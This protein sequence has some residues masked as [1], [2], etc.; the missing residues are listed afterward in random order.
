MK[1]I[2]VLLVAGFAGLSF[3][4]APVVPTIQEQLDILRRGKDHPTYQI[5]DLRVKDTAVIGG[6]VTISGAQSVSGNQTVSGL[7]TATKGF[8]TTTGKV[9]T[10]LFAATGTASVDG[11]I[12]AAAGLTSTTGKL[13]TALLTS[14]DS[15]TLGGTTVIVTNN[16]R[17]DKKL[18]VTGDLSYGTMVSN[19]AGSLVAGKLYLYGANTNKG[20]LAVVGTSLVYIA[21]VWAGTNMAPAQTS[22][23]VGVFANVP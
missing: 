10:A 15:T 16:A 9:S 21:E 17:I 11:L 19:T 1:R 13:T 23:V 6:A 20:Y 8:S 14:T 2:L 3:A 18:T 12:T 22:T 5:Q 7:E 4:Q